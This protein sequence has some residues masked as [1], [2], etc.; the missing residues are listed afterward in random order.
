ML[1]ERL[2]SSALEL[3]ENGRQPRHRLA[4]D[5]ETRRR[6]SGGQRD[7]LLTVL[8]QVEGLHARD[9]RDDHLRQ[10]G[11]LVEVVDDEVYSD[12]LAYSRCYFHQE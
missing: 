6:T 2:G 8:N 4:D 11:D 7:R 10:Q 3:R 5:L 9:S 1:F 12:L